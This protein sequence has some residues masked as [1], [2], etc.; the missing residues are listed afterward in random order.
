M[1][2]GDSDES[3]PYEDNGRFVEKA[4]LAASVPFHAF[5]KPGC[6]HHP[7]GLA[8]PTPVVELLLKYGS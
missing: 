4:Y 8:D 3:V 6:G 2:Y 5:C 7:H 1:V